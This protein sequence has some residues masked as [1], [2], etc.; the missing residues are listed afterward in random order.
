MK[1]ERQATDWSEKENN[2][3]I[4]PEMVE[5]KIIQEEKRTSNVLRILLNKLRTLFRS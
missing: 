3:Q 1:N 5:E 2:V 4:E